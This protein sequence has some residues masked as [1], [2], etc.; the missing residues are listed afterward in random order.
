MALLASMPG[1]GPRTGARILAGIG[2]GS[3]FRDGSKLA[4]LI[5]LAR[6][7]C[8]VILAIL[9]TGQPYQPARHNDTLSQAA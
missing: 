2:D 4:A 9:R 7:R 3:A 6:R 1:I 8:D 5:C